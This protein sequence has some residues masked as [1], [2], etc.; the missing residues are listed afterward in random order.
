MLPWALLRLAALGRDAHDV[1]G[2]ESGNVSTQSH[3]STFLIA[4]DAIQ[5]G[6]L[7]KFWPHLCDLSS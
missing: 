2:P 1:P 6:P 4:S 5:A 7:A 3:N